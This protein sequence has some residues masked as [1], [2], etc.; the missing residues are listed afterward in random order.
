MLMLMVSSEMAPIEHSTDKETL[1]RQN[2][3]IG[4]IML[5]RKSVLI[6]L[7]CEINAL[8]II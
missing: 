2:E 4:P 7:L 8:N 1:Y 5:R 3:V 6:D